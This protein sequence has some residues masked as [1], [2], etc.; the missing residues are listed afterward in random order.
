MLGRVGVY[1]EAVQN[2]EFRRMT[3][4]QRLLSIDL[5]LAVK[6]QPALDR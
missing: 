3:F 5:K 2:S 1:G 6:I 4:P